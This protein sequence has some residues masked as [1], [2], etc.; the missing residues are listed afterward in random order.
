MSQ[1]REL[2][3]T[4]AVSFRPQVSSEQ[5][6]SVIDAMAA[7]E[8]AAT[9]CAAAMVAEDDVRVLQDAI[10]RDLNCADVVAAARRVV[11]RGA[12]AALLGSLLEACVAA[13]EH[14]AEL[15]GRH[16]HHH[17]HC[18]ICSQ[19]TSRCAEACRAILRG[20]HG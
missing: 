16:A 1:T 15:C 17:D 5:L 10:I 14:S 6:A 12:D 19:A 8:E 7:C 3:D 9:A 13:C 2:L 18:R 20:L 11:S 4:L